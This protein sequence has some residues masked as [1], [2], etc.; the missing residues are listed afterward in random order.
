MAMIRAISFFKILK[1]IM[2]PW[3][4]ILKTDTQKESSICYSEVP[5]RWRGNILLLEKIHEL[6]NAEMIELKTTI[7]QTQM[8]CKVLALLPRQ[9]L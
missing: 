1:F 5:N 9:L 2:G 6:I 3:F 7:L 4:V 8:K